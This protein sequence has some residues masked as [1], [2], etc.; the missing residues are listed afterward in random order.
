MRGGVSAER[1]MS[2]LRGFGGFC[3]CSPRGLPVNVLRWWV[4]SLSRLLGLASSGRGS[5]LCC[6]FS[7]GGP[8]SADASL[9]GLAALRL[10]GWLAQAGAFCF[11][12]RGSAS[13]GARWWSARFSPAGAVGPGRFS[14]CALSAPPPVGS[15]GRSLFVFPCGCRAS[16]C[17]CHPPP[18]IWF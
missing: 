1:L 11:S 3:F 10:Q 9:V 7:A 6:L 8:A 12:V 14:G 18:P 5:C 13:G 16:D 2:C 15:S 4:G 17:R